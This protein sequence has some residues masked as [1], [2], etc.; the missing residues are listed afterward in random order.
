MVWNFGR[1]ETSLHH[2]E[3]SAFCCIRLVIMQYKNANE[4]PGSLR[5][6]TWF[7][8]ESKTAS[9]CSLSLMKI[10]R[11]LDQF[12]VEFSRHDFKKNHTTFTSFLGIICICWQKC[13]NASKRWFHLIN[14]CFSKARNIRGAK[15]TIFYQK[16][17][18]L[19]Y[20]HDRSFYLF[21][22]SNVS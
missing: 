18:N 17:K 3:A 15:G 20:C 1:P 2:R 22:K 19:Y 8:R 7:Q 16:L 11:K 14:Q 12:E 10:L 13:N 6:Y 5:S 9:N 4:K 21:Y